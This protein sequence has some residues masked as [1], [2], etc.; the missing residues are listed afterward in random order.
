ML[1]LNGTCYLYLLLMLFRQVDILARI[2][3]STLFAWLCVTS[4]KFPVDLYVR[5][6]RK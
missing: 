3:I 1:S 5:S 4:S 2:E 6:G